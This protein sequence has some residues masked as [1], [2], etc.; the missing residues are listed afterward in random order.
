[1]SNVFFDNTYSTIQKQEYE[2][3]SAQISAIHE[4]LHGRQ[5][6]MTAWVDW[7][8]MADEGYLLKIEQIAAEIKKEST[9]LVVI[10]IGGSYVGSRACINLMS[11]SF[12][13]QKEGLKIYFAG[14]NLSAA[15][16][17]ELI[18]E[19]EN[20]EVSICVIS[21]SGSTME[22]RSAY[23]L[24]KDLLLQK[25]GNH[26]YKR[27]YVITENNDGFLRQEANKHA[28]TA[29]DLRSDIG[30]RYSVLTSVGLLPICAAGY[31]IRKIIQG[32][33]QAY[34]DCLDAD[35]LKNECYQYAAA[36]RILNEKGKSIEIFSSFEPKMDYFLEWLKQLFGESEGKEG[37]GI[38]PASLL[39]SRDLHSMGQFIQEG[40]QIFFETM[41][42]FKQSVIKSGSG[43]NELSLNAQNDIVYR[44]VIKAHSQHDIP[45]VTFTLNKMDEESFGYC[46]YFFQKACA[47]SCMIL[48]V[49]PFNQPGVEIYKA[50]IRKLLKKD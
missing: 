3:H 6:D 16:H 42:N 41:I 20:E 46:A 43:Q 47:V 4:M 11:N 49:N 21:K 9:A 50:E 37:K 32:A 19:L 25:Y 44:S 29:L 35:I 30:G 31:D 1:M 48:G 15:Y 28:Y 10:G 38:F 2:K 40:N 34:T 8:N 27:V 22:I 26:F 39:F 12:S 13:Y 45:I 7:P 23:R 33:R 36:R 24:F 18:R 5:M 17:N 14:W